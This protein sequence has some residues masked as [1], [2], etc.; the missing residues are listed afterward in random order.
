VIVIEASKEWGQGRFGAW[1]EDADC[2][3]A[4]KETAGALDNVVNT[5]ADVR[6]HYRRTMLDLTQT[7]F[8]RAK[9]T[10]KYMDTRV[11]AALSRLDKA[12]ASVKRE[13]A[14]LEKKH[15]PKAGNTSETIMEGE[16]RAYLRTLP[17][18]G[19]VL[20]LGEAVAL[21]DLVT[22][23]AALLAPPVLL[24]IPEHLREEIETA[25]ARV[26]DP[27]GFE[28]RGLLEKAAAMIERSGRALMEETT[29][30]MPPGIA[31]ASPHDQTAAGRAERLVKLEQQR[32]AA[33]APIA[34]PVS[35]P[36]LSATLEA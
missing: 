3:G 19:Q 8:G 1:P 5:W 31:K 10:G 28:R 32:A 33:E 18:H 22:L 20:K 15:K 7:P 6:T 17:D 12:A 4:L 11:E 35:I 9:A 30:L 24:T 16:V 25:Y 34:E 2:D 29:R 13:L 26:V 23:R 21:G 36:P 14:E 27:E